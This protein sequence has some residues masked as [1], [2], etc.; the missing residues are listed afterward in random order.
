MAG[1][2]ISFSG[3]ERNLGARLTTEAQ[4]L[5]AQVK[6]N[7]ALNKADPSDYWWWTPDAP[8]AS[9]LA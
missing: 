5:K 7:P 1:A 9:G 2:F 4:A 6:D 8:W 3:Q